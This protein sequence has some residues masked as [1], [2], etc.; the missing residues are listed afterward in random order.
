M[1]KPPRTPKRQPDR[2]QQNDQDEVVAGG[3]KRVQILRA[4]EEH[5]DER[6]DHAPA[7]ELPLPGLAEHEEDE[8]RVEEILASGHAAMIRGRRRRVIGA[9]VEPRVDL[10]LN[11]RVGGGQT[12]L[13]LCQVSC[14]RSSA[15]CFLHE[16]ADPC[17]FAAVNSASAKAVGR[18]ALSSRFLVAEAECRVPRLEL[19]ALEEADDVAVVGARR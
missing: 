19:R 15:H 3:R 16:R 6:N 12:H 7:V 17:F 5:E 14:S 2:G 4:D 13:A 18:M 1:A 9:G 8:R 11:P 10:P